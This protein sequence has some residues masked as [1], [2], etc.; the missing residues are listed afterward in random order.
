MLGDFGSQQ[1]M[2]GTPRTSRESLA[3]VG[4]GGEAREQIGHPGWSAPELQEGYWRAVSLEADI[5]SLGK[6]LLYL[7]TDSVDWKDI[8]DVPL[9]SIR[10]CL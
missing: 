7:L 6:L 3:K 2:S 1:S 4:G 5:F 9:V 10:C 8:T